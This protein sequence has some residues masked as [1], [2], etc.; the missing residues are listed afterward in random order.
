MRVGR[1]AIWSR[2]VRAGWAGR[3]WGS[4]EGGERGDLGQGCQ[5]GVGGEVVGEW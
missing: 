5:G 4:G 3:W 2:G 1:G